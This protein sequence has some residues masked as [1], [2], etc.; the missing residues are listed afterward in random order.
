MI[1]ELRCNPM[2]PRARGRVTVT[3]SDPVWVGDEVEERRGQATP[4][5]LDPSSNFPLAITGSAVPI[6]LGGCPR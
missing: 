5:G 6:A 2:S 1:R 4:G 3:F